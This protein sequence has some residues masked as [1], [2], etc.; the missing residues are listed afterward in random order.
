MSNNNETRSQTCA[1]RSLI[2]HFKGLPDPRINRTR[3][4]ALVD[5][6]VI[7]ICT[8]L[9]GA[10][11]FDDMEDFGHAKR[12]WLK[13]FLELSA[14]IPSHDTFN[15]VF[16]AL[17]PRRFQECFVRWTQSLRTAISGEIVAIDGRALRRAMN[18]G[19][20]T[21]HI[22]NAWARRNALVLGQF[23]VAD[24]SN[25]ITAVPELLRALEPSGC[26]VTADA[27]GCQK[28]IAREIV[29]ADADYVLALKG[30]QET[31]H[32]EVKAYLDDAILRQA[33]PPPPVKGAGTPP[34]WTTAKSW[35]RIMA[36]S[37]P[38]ATGRANTWIGSRTGPNGRNSPVWA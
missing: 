37:K 19:Q 6:L 34:N 27:M 4:H 11:S 21:K 20:S 17:D 16:A 9:C 2:D 8:L 23:K 12:D 38:A 18:K 15:R 7:G 32:E 24:K 26:I 14:R 1:P 5:I 33:L 30:N 35:R 25:E 28:K 31:V 29:E 10:E 36:G 3:D 22:V 13:T